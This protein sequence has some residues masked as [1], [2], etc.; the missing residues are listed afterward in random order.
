MEESPSLHREPD[1]AA[2]MAVNAVHS[3]LTQSGIV[4]RKQR[5]VWLNGVCQA[6]LAREDRAN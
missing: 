1:K 5:R 2:E 4:D 3:Y 6:A